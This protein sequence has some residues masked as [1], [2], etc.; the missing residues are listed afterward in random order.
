M[1]LHNAFLCD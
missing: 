1:A